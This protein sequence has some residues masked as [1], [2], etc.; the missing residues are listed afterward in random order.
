MIILDERRNNDFLSREWMEKLIDAGIDVSDNAYIIGKDSWA[1]TDEN[2]DE[3]IVWIEE[4]E[5]TDQVYD[6]VPTL[7]ISELYN[8]LGNNSDALQKADF[9]SK[10]KGMPLIEALA[11]T[12]I[13]YE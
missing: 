9:I 10:E 11:Y 13:N 1:V 5:S 3:D 7:T 2:G 6:V 12:L 4:M 8:K